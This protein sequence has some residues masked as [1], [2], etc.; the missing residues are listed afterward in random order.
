MLGKINPNFLTLHDS[1]MSFNYIYFFGDYKLLDGIFKQEK[2]YVISIS[3][4]I[5]VY[6]YYGIIFLFHSIVNENVRIVE[7]KKEI[8]D[9]MD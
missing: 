3:L 5:L 2:S 9:E 6:I 1:F 4:F 7:T 8:F